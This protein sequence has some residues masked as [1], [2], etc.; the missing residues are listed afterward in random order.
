[1]KPVRTWILIANNGKARIVENDGP[2]KGLYQPRGLAHTSPGGADFDDQ[3]GRAFSSVGEARSK[4][5]QHQSGRLQSNAFASELVDE[6]ILSKR[7]K[8]FDRLIIC[9]PPT[10]LGRVRALLPDDLKSDL[11]AE[12][13]KDLTGIPTSNLSNHFTNF[14]AV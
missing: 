7:K 3:P 13:P 4:M 10:M 9:A 8:Q 14:L 5:E 12:L 2:G 11:I 6:L 1:M